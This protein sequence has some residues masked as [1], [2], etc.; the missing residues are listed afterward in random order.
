ME[1]WGE[2]REGQVRFICSYIAICTKTGKPFIDIG[3][4][5][6]GI[7]SIVKIICAGTDGVAAKTV[8]GISRIE[9]REEIGQQEQRGEEKAPHDCGLGLRSVA[10]GS[11][12]MRLFKEHTK[13]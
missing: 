3:V 12:G 2:Y 7:A 10:L 5:E 6:E 13:P 8:H 9:D 11:I 4:V 1:F